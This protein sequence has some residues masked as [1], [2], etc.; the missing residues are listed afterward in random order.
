MFSR[1]WSPASCLR[2]YFRSGWAFLIPYL[3]V[4]LLYYLQKWPV[5]AVTGEGQLKV[6]SERET[7]V[8]CLLYVYWILHA[9]NAFLAAIALSAWWREKR[10]TPALGEVAG[11][12]V[13]HLTS[14]IG[15][16]PSA[17]GGSGL[18]PPASRLLRIAPWLLLGL[19]FW[20]PGVYLE[21]PA[22][23]WQH[24]SRINKWSGLQT[25]GEHSV[26]NKSSY[27]LAYSLLGQIAPPARQLFW[28]D[29]YYT[30]CCLLLCWQ[31]YRLVRAVGLGGRASMLFVLLQAFLFGNNL[32]GFYRYYGIS[33]TIFAQLGAIALIRWGFQVVR[34]RQETGDGREDS[35]PDL[36]PPASNLERS[37]QAIPAAL[38]LALTAFNHSQGLGI[39][40]LGLAAVAG[41]RLIEWRRSMI[42][43]LAVAALVLSVTAVLWWPR[44]PALDAAYRPAGW[45]TAWYGFNVWSPSSPAGDRTL[46]ILGFFGV[47]NL[48]A[49]LLLLRRNHVAGW[50]T[51]FPP[52][53]LGLPFIAMPFAGALAQH[54]NDWGNII[55]FHR[56]LLAIP[57]GLAMVAFTDGILASR[58]SRD[59]GTTAGTNR[60]KVLSWLNGATADGLLMCA[61]PA[62]LL[63]PASGPYY[64][65]FWNAL[66]K[67]PDDL[68]MKHVIAA[69]SR[70]PLIATKNDHPS[71]VF[72]TPGIGCVVTAT[73]FNNVVYIE[74]RLIMSSVLSTPTARMD[75]LLGRV[76]SVVKDGR[77]DSLLLLPLVTSLQTAVSLT[78]SLST[79]W[80]PQEVALEHAG[81]PEIEAAARQLGGKEIQTANGTY[82]SFGDQ[83]RP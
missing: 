15:D 4:Y 16:S 55:T 62:L 81:G 23:P 2:R 7:W 33:S 76:T 12:D 47:V 38:L 30:G 27:F 61:L 74:E 53:A 36:R 57:A 39:A 18:P 14:D 60:A 58:K 82:Y 13:R 48:A 34:G 31:Y 32:F 26:W 22:D 70:S 83:R 59:N 63:V 75:H 68:G 52:L 8:P 71:V 49:G 66:M 29:L 79:H 42:W 6:A 77:R 37:L 41:W 24:Y 21:Y 46:Q 9:I 54:N 56:A 50:L 44:H 69:A 43:W 19:L 67:P 5:N 45:L 28:L 1:L 35:F 80:L 51:V 78:G 64:N 10:T 17:S 11:A 3:A 65:R 20:I 25:V 72:T 73:G 40:G